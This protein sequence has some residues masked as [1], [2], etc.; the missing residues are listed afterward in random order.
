MTGFPLEDPLPLAGL[1]L[2]LGMKRTHSE[3]PA[4]P[5]CGRQ[6]G[7]RPRR[8]TRQRASEAGED[9]GA[10]S[11]LSPEM[12]IICGKINPGRWDQ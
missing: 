11:V 3:S 1:A 8:Q 5:K 7:S 2:A 9:K 4:R 6:A 12:G 10:S